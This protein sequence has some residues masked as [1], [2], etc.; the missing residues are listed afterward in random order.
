MT[1]ESDICRIETKLPKFPCLN[2]GGEIAPFSFP[3]ISWL[4]LYEPTKK[5]V[6]YGVQYLPQIYSV[7]QAEKDFFMYHAWGVIRRF[8][9]RYFVGNFDNN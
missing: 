5:F 8:L 1:P 9:Y 4:Y 3:E 6:N 2:L 7:R